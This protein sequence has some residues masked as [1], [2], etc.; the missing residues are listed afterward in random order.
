MIAWHKQ[1]AKIKTQTIERWFTTHKLGIEAFTISEARIINTE[2]WKLTIPEKMNTCRVRKR[3]RAKEKRNKIVCL[4]ALDQFQFS[5]FL[6]LYAHRHEYICKIKNRF[7]LKILSIIIVTQR[8]ISSNKQ[9]KRKKEK[10]AKTKKNQKKRKKYAKKAK[11]IQ[12]PIKH[13]I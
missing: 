3:K 13:L 10:M 12:N 6:P 1:K 4:C 5:Q 11:G 7:S 9:T 2:T 8:N